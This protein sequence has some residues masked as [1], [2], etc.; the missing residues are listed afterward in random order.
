MTSF[1][2]YQIRIG[3]TEVSPESDEP[4]CWAC[5]GH[6]MI[7]GFVGGGAPGYET[8]TC[9]TCKGTGH[10]TCPACEGGGWESYGLGHNDPH[11]RECETCNNPEGFPSP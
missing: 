7:G 1:I 8:E 11:F 2:A 4:K 3:Q 5:D 6:G 9:G 10:A